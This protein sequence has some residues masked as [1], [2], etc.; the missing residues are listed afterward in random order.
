MAR[1][2]LSQPSALFCQLLSGRSVLNA[3]KCNEDLGYA[4]I[5]HPFH[6]FK[7]QR[8][9]VLK[10]RKLAGENTIIIQ[11]SYRGTFA[12]PIEWTD[13]ADPTPYDF[14]KTS[15]PILSFR[16]LIALTEIIERLEEKRVDK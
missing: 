1:N 6:P 15:P 12:V 10:R 7:D 9:K 2:A 13:Q 16:C 14:E 3:L 11:G 4:T 5:T 8:F